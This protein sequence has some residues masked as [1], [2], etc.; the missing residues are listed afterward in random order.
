M[1]DHQLYLGLLETPKVEVIRYPL[2][3][4]DKDK[5][6]ASQ[7]LLHLVEIY[8]PDLVLVALYLD[9]IDHDVLDKIKAQTCLLGYCFDSAWRFENFERG[10]APHFTAMVL[11]N[12]ISIPRYKEHNL[13]FIKSMYGCL[14]SR[15]RPLGIPRQYD[16]SFVGGNHGNRMEVISVLK[17]RGLNVG[18]F[19]IGWPGS[20]E[21]TYD[22]VVQIFNQSWINLN[23][24]NASTGNFQQ[25]KGRHFEIPGCNVFQLSSTIPEIVEYFEP[26]KEIAL[27]E[28]LEDLYEKCIYYLTHKDELRI[29]AQNA[30]ERTLDEHTWA[31]RFEEIFKKV[32]FR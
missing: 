32:G 10:I 22:E 28:S 9:Q 6:L 19:G 5:R 4:M 24:A 11:T 18:V 2:E 30:Y 3:L 23:L 21:I 12:A 14:V 25:V 31:H 29:I 8:K 17:S 16:V 15:F 13:P 7:H 27:F 20:R 1:S 26:L